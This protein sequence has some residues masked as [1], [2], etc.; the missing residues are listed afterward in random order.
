M[1]NTTEPP[2]PNA[3]RMVAL[4]F[5][6]KGD[7][8]RQLQAREEHHARILSRTAYLAERVA[9]FRFDQSYDVHLPPE[10]RAGIEK[11]LA[12]VRE[13][14]AG[15]RGYAKAGRWPEAEKHYEDAERSAVNAD[16]WIRL[17]R[18]DATRAARIARY[19]RGGATANQKRS[20]KDAHRY[21][22]AAK[23]LR[24]ARPEMR[25]GAL[26]AHLRRNLPEPHKSKIQVYR[27][28]KAAGLK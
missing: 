4:M 5:A 9:A 25:L 11:R 8:Q 21:V 1:P 26:V 27:Y 20:E 6:A 18:Q 14:V 16:L 7:P 19:Q 28:L 17:G 23:R 2:K 3:L 12:R 13:L 24:R 10:V 15:V 22:R